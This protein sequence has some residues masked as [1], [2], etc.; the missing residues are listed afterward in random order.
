MEACASAQY[1]AR[2]LLELGRDVRLIAAQFVK[3]FVK[4]Q[5]NDFNAAE[6]IAEALSRPSM[7]FVAARTIEQLEL[8]GAAPRS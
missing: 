1:W 5:N 2:R 6:A 3:P 7:R 4:S 8:Q